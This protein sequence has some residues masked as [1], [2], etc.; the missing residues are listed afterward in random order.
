VLRVISFGANAEG[1]PVLAAMQML[2]VLAYRACRRV[3]SLRSWLA[4]GS[5]A[6]RSADALI[7]AGRICSMDETVRMHGHAVGG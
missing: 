6:R 7:R 2:H 4:L 1:A 5:Y 3:S